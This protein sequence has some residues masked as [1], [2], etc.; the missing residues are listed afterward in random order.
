MAEIRQEKAARLHAQETQEPKQKSPE[1]QDPSAKKPRLLRLKKVTS[2]GQDISD[3]CVTVAEKPEKNRKSPPPQEPSSNDIK[4]KTFEEIMREK[5]LRQL[6][7]EE[8]ASSSCQTK[9]TANTDPLVQKPSSPAFK[10][11]VAAKI[12][13]TPDSSTTSKTV[14]LQAKATPATSASFK[15]SEADCHSHKTDEKTD[16]APLSNALKAQTDVQTTQETTVNTKVRPKLNVKPSVVKPTARLKPG[17]KRKAPQRSAV[18]AVKPLNSSSKET[19]STSQNN[20]VLSVSPDSPQSSDFL[21]NSVTSS[22]SACKRS[23]LSQAPECPLPDTS[24]VTQSHT[25]KSP[26]QVKSR[27]SSVAASRLSSSSTAPT[28]AVDD[29]EKLIS[30]FTT[31]EPLDDSVDPALGEDDLL[32]E[33]SDMID[34]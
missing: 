17:Q 7:P 6:D 27:R 21:S 1:L 30:E 5:R 15:D 3:K 29:F 19:E 22:D 34:S 23:P 14:V 2:P 28:S 10:R 8:Q 25:L 31:D 24:T 9:P 11:K 13:F 26:T 33:L 20:Q 4:V 18:A 16:A 12:T 32:Q